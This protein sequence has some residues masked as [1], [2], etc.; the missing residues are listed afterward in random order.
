MTDRAALIAAL[1][2]A[3]KGS[4]ELDR[5]PNLMAAAAMTASV[6]Q[7]ECAH[8]PVIGER[9]GGRPGGE[10]GLAAAK[11]AGKEGVGLMIE[12]GAKRTGGWRPAGKTW[13]RKERQWVVCWLVFKNNEWPAQP[14][15]G[16]KR[17]H[18]DG[19]FFGRYGK[20]KRR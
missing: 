12:Q 5:A 19:P 16:Y 7:E 10:S 3:T 14:R 4:R 20:R 2:A 18:S 15:T 13:P 1:E 8:Q 17:V 11:G 9:R 6:E